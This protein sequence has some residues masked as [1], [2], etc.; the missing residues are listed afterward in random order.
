[1][2]TF[3]SVV[4]ADDLSCQYIATETYKK[5]IT[6]YFI[7]DTEANISEPFASIV[8]V[9]TWKEYPGYNR[10]YKFTVKNNIN[11]PLNLTVTY[12]LIGKS[13]S[14]DMHLDP[15]GYEKVQGQ[16]PQ[17]QGGLGE[18]SLDIHSITTIK[19]TIN[20]S[21]EVC[22]KCLGIDC[23]NDGSPCTNPM[24]CGGQNCVEGYC[25]NSKKCFNND[26][27]CS[28]DELQCEDNARCVKRTSLDIGSKPICSFEEC[29]TKYIDPKTGLC[30]KSPEQ[31][32]QEEKDTLKK[33][34]EKQQQ[35]QK[36]AEDRRQ[37]LLREEQEKR[38]K[39]IL[40]GTVFIGFLALAIIAVLKLKNDNVKAKAELLSKQKELEM[41]TI[42]KMK[43]ELNEIDNQIEAIKKIKNKREEEIKHLE[44]LEAQQ[45]EIIKNI[46][47]QKEEIRTPFGDPQ[48]SNRLVVKNPYLGGYKCFYT[49][50][51]P[52]EKY[53]YSSLV[54]RWVW[55]KHNGRNPRPGYHIHHIDRNKDNNDPRNLEEV[56]GVE[57]FDM[58]K[59]VL[60]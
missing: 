1:M 24:A 30:A 54:H 8:D 47:K 11:Y 33:E 22:K 13:N 35:L 26:C 39:Q 15:F 27:I 17:D 19:Y 45:K 3:S 46:E 34:Q 28:Q 10:D 31:I 25:S 52:L 12:I 37:Q 44:K 2:T 23:L 50:G 40:G 38:D 20:E 48:A 41:L 32:T 18:I 58:H 55:K 59:E 49:E 21:K 36:E 16:Y 56:E 43:L 5:E 9:N 7:D 14:R 60:K 53:P 42:E 6:K 51:M 29:T 4:Y 57:H